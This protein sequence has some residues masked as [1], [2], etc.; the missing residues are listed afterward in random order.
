MTMQPADHPPPAAWPVPPSPAVPAPAREAVRTH[1][2]MMAVDIVSF[3]SR[4]R[5]ERVQRELRHR[6]YRLLES[7]FAMTCLP[8]DAAHREDRGDGALI[9]LPRQVPTY[10][11]LDPLAHHL[12]ALLRRDNLWYVD[13]LRMRLR[14]AVHTGYVH[15]DAYGVLG[16]SVNHLFRLLDSAALRAMLD[17]TGGDLGMIASDELFGDVT[18]Y[19]GLTDT[20]R[21]RAVDVACKETRTRGWIW[22]A[23]G[24]AA[25]GLHVAS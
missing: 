25:P 10:L 15:R 24:E 19:S 9:I 1:T 22:L 6:L 14:V 7:T 20:G 16:R 4:Q 18:D 23:P 8:W 13:P 21:Y 12:H 11:L 3:G 5:D 2:S 17:A